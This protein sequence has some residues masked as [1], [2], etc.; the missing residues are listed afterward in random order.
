MSVFI[1]SKIGVRNFLIWLTIYHI[2]RHTYIHTERKILEDLF[3]EYKFHFCDTFIPVDL[4]QK[5]FIF[6]SKPGASYK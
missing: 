5:E 2:H 4:D 6:V 3:L 1:L